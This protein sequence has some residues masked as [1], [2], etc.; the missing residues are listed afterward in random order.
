MQG[1]E[2]SEQ[3]QQWLN[4]QADHIMQPLF[5]QIVKQRP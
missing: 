4:Q 1:Q 5:L 2:L 3:N